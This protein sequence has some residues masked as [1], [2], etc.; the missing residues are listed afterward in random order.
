MSEKNIVSI[1]EYMIGVKTQKANIV[2][3]IPLAMLMPVSDSFSMHPLFFLAL[4]KK[5][6]IHGK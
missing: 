3:T 6:N 1:K 4:N 5:Y 2:S